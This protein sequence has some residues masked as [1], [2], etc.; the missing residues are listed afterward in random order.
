MLFFYGPYGVT[1]R[2]VQVLPF[3]PSSTLPRDIPVAR[4]QEIR[5]RHAIPELYVF[6]PAQ[7]WPHKNH[8]RIVEALEQLKRLH[9]FRVPAV[10]CGSH[11]G[12]QRERHFQLLMDM[13]RQ[14]GVADQI[15]VLGYVPDDELAALYA[16]A[17]ALVMPTF[18]GPTNIP[19]IAPAL[20]ATV[21]PDC[22]ETLAAC[23]VRTLARTEMFIPM[24]PVTPESTAPS[25]KPTAESGLS[26]QN[27]NAAT[28]TPTIAIARYCRAR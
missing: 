18:F 23:A 2:Q 10:F 20:N 4:Q 19:V 24:K 5:R 28:T 14:C 7:F 22:S 9:Q 25:T 16:G 27:T 15:H 26:S 12:A 6:Y 21:R 8:L 11:T 3:M 17:A 1:E 13:A